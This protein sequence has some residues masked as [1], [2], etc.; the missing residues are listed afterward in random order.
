MSWCPKIGKCD[1]QLQYVGSLQTCKD[2]Q[3]FVGVIFLEPMYF[4]GAFTLILDFVLEL[5][6]CVL[7]STRKYAGSQHYFVLW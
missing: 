5:G 2:V 4:F 6:T 3:K 1:V 7:A